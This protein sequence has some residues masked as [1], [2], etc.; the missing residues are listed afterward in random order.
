MKNIDFIQSV[1]DYIDENMSEALDLDVIAVATG[2]SKYH[3][4]RMFAFCTG[5]SIHEYVRRRRLTEAARRLVLTK[6]RIIDISLECGY[7]NQQS[8]TNGFESVFGETPAQYRKNK[9]FSPVQLKLRV[10]PLKT[11]QG[12]HIMNIRTEKSQKLTL[13]G[14]EAN[15]AEGF[16]VIGMCWGQL[17]GRKVE[18]SN[19]T[20]MDFLVGINDYSNYEEPEDGQKSFLYYAGAEVSNADNIPE[21]MIV[22]KLPTT[23]YV[24]FSYKGNCQDSMEPVAEYIYKEWF[25]QSTCVMNEN[26]QYDFVRY[27]ESMDEEGKNL[28]E[29]WVPVK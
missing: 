16:Q 11:L 20:D 6:E 28:I 22:K 9:T 25:P 24:V 8:F 26:A 27:G 10:S 23:D 19:R 5:Y 13:V 18:I 1:V 2:Y 14:F 17:H 3:L 7:S 4:S 12:D 21:G 15:T 29:Y